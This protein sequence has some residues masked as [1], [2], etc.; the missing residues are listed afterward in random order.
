M[1]PD[2][3]AKELLEAAIVYLALEPINP[4]CKLLSGVLQS[5][6]PARKNEIA[7]RDR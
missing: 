3:F 1:S 4:V 5:R 6:I 7:Q 2:E